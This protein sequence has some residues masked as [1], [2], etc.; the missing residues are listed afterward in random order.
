MGVQ[1]YDWS[2]YISNGA[3]E[4]TCPAAPAPATTDCVAPPAPSTAASRL[5]RTFAYLSAKNVRNVEL[6]GYSGNPFPVN[7]TTPLNTAGLTALR[8]LGDSY[9][10]RF[11]SRHGSLT[12]TNWDQEIAAAK[13]LGQEVIGAAD[14]LNAGSSSLQQNLT[15]AQLMNRIGKRSV[16]AGVGPA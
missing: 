10:L 8:A 7:N 1:L 14:P 6:F 15:N 5:E 11:V 4:I 3:G 13:I 2:N 16:E 12:E 9:G